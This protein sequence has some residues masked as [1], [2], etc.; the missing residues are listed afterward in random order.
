MYRKNSGKFDVQV[1]N[2]KCIHA[3]MR[4]HYQ[5]K[6]GGGLYAGWG[7]SGKSQ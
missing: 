1:S 6:V 4:K 3:Q 5:I 2:K 7:R